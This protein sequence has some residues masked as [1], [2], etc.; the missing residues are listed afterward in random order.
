MRFP[1][2]HG[3]KVVFSYAGDIYISSAN[4]GVAR[5]LTSD[6]GYEMFPRFSPDGKYIAF[7]GQ[8]DG[9]SEVYVISS[10]GGVP[11][12]VTYS[13]TLSRDD[14]GDRMGPNNVVI[15]WTPDGKKILYRTRAYTFNDFTGQ[16]MPV[17]IKGPYSPIL[18]EPNALWLKSR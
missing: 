8:F 1:D 4:G 18:S 12:R 17:G 13:A 3:D 11:R 7:T 10:D 9:N 15:D 2:I 5:K 6:R 16:L 14:V